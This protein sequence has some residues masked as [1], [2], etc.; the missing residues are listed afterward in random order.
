MTVEF[1]DGPKAGEKE[2][3]VKPPPKRARY[4]W[5]EWATYEFHPPNRMHYIGDVRINSETGKFEYYDGP[6]ES[7]A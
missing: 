4:A 1:M 2:V 6:P 3:I 7:L 5:P